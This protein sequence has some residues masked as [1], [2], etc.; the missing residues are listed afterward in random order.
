MSSNHPV[1]NFGR[2]QRVSE[3]WQALITPGRWPTRLVDAL[4]LTSP[5]AVTS[6]VVPAPASLGGAST[7]RVAFASDFHAGPYTSTRVFDQAMQALADARPDVLLLG[8]DFV[9]L[10]SDFVALIAPRFADVPAPAGKFAVLGNHDYYAGA[11]PIV[12]ALEQ[13]GVTL[14]TNRNAQ[15]PAPFSSVSICGLDDHTT[16]YPDAARAFEGAAPVRILLMHEPSGLLDAGDAHFML[17]LAG[18]THGGQI[19]LPGGIPL[20]LPHGALTRTYVRG[21]HDVG[22]ER[23]L[24]VSRGLGQSTLPIRWNASPEVHIIDITAAPG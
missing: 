8:G 15:L 18:H 1:R 3:Q 22:A 2:L 12:R 6:T 13:A 14:L 19:A 20:V 7:L 9:S 23:T 16:G 21:Q 11:A 17:A 24:I 5:L 4:R 10:R